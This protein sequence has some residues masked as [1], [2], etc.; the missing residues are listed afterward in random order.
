M[1]ALETVVWRYKI[2]C[3]APGEYGGWVT[4]TDREYIEGFC[5]RMGYLIEPL[6]P[7]APAQAEIE[8]LTEERDTAQSAVEA[9]ASVCE[10]L[11][12]HLQDR[13]AMK[14][15]PN[16]EA[17]LS[18]LQSR[19]AR[20]RKDSEQIRAARW[21]HLRSEREQRE[22]AEAR[23][24]SAEERVKVLSE[25]LEHIAKMEVEEDKYGYP[26]EA[27]QQTALAALQQ[28]EEAR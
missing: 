12:A 18:I 21:S 24:L 11:E 14:D 20:V 22:Q 23:A 1:S 2:K 10:G 19:M 3:P 8:R 9:W 27:A 16:P 26:S 7:L 4:A 6:T 25:A 28:K 5:A 17:Y 15:Y 13:V